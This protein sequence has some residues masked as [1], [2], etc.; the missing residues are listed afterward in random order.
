MRDK[1]NIPDPLVILRTS[2][3]LHLPFALSYYILIYITPRNITP[4]LSPFLSSPTVELLAPNVALA[5]TQSHPLL[6][7]PPSAARL[8][9]GSLP[10]RNPHWW[11]KKTSAEKQQQQQKKKKLRLALF[12]TCTRATCEL[13]YWW[14]VRTPFSTPSTWL[15]IR[16]DFFLPTVRWEAS[17]FSSAEKERDYTIGELQQQQRPR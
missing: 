17:F 1:Q 4:F 12:S 3:L 14:G 11:G 2:S 16:P 9:R 15:R 6:F 7:S 8:L 10:T 5:P 13:A